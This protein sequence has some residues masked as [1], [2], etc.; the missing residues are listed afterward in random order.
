MGN[1]HPIGKLNRVE[2]VEAYRAEWLWPIVE[3]GL[4]G[5]WAGKPSVVKRFT[6]TEGEDSLLARQPAKK[7]WPWGDDDTVRQAVWEMVRD[8]ALKV[9]AGQPVNLL[10]YCHPLPCHGDVL[11]NCLRWLAKRV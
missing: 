10:C 4:A 2:A 7:G 5:R 1:P 3:A 6:S 8:L 11:A 9:K